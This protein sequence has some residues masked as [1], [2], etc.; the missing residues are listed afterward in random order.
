MSTVR[1]P[2]AASYESRDD[3]A[4]VNLALAG[5][6]GAF[7]TIMKRHNRRIY[8]VARGILGDDS[9]A[10][11]VVQETYIK[12]YQHLADFRAESSLTTWLTRIAINEALGRKRKRRATVDLSEIETLDEQGEVCVVIFPGAAAAVGPESAA[13]RAQIR[14]LLETAMDDL[15]EAFRIVFVMRDVE[16]M[17]IEETSQ[18]LGVLPETV[19]TRLHRARRL[20]RQA[21]QEKL[22]SAL[23]DTYAFDGARCDRLTDSVMARLGLSVPEA[24]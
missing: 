21:L 8:R 15:P 4:L 19:K 6:A 5:N 16:Q 24:G 3:L 17:S 12:A 23:D 22:G 9:D 13:M 20:L 2:A 1:N 14:R 10:E 11:D 18:Q 7:R